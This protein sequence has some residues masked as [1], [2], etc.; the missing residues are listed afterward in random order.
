MY[1]DLNFHFEQ[2]FCRFAFSTCLE[3]VILYTIKQHL[4]NFVHFLYNYSFISPQ[5][6]GMGFTA[7]ALYLELSVNLKIIWI[8][9]LDK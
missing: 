2:V 4:H 9:F 5:H 7:R 3:C 1:T 8:I 6:E